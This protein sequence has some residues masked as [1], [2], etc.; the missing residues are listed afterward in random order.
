MTKD[1]VSQ[2]RLIADDTAIY[3]A[4][5]KSQTCTRYCT[6]IL[7]LNPDLGLKNTHECKTMLHAWKVHENCIPV[8][9]VD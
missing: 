2:V 8:P 3:L 1:I 7:V 4:Q 9:S 6:K 5:E